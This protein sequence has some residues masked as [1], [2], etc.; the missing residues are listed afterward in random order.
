MAIKPAKRRRGVYVLLVLLAATCIGI[1]LGARSIRHYFLEL[2]HP[3]HYSTIVESYAAERGIDPYLV[4]AV[5]KTESGFQPNAV[6][7][8]GARGLMQLMQ[9]A[10]D[11]TKFRMGDGSE[12]SYDNM[13][14]PDT[15][16]KFG[17]YMLKL[18]LEEYD[19]N[20]GTAI[21]AYH[22]GRGQVNGWLKD[23]QYSDDGVTLKSIPIKDTA[24]YVDKVTRAWESYRE[25]YNHKNA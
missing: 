6:S 18:L 7:S 23:T 2:S 24:H 21:A 9:D 15:N 12:T 3:I 5:I 16:V 1:F 8:V 20:V 14:D 17:T 22:A 19:G 13:F 25:L 11:W 10:F 4:Y